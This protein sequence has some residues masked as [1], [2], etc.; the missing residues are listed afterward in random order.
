MKYLT[1]PKKEARDSSRERILTRRAIFL[2]L[3]LG[4]FAPALAASA[5]EHPVNQ[6]I[7]Q[8]PCEGA[9]SPRL[10]YEGSGSYDPGNQKWIHHGGHDSHPQG[11]H[12][13]TFDLK[14]GV[15]EKK[16]PNTS[17]EGV[18]CVNGAYIFDTVNQRFVRFPG[19][20]LGHGYQWSRGVMLKK[21]PVWLY[22]LAANRWT[23]MRPF[24]YTPSIGLGSLNA[25]AAYD[26]NRALTI[27]FGGQGGGNNLFVYD[28]YSNHL[29]RMKAENPPSPRDG[30]GLCYDSKNDV[31]VMFGS[32][33]DD[34][35][36]TWLYRYSTGKWESHDLTP[37]PVGRKVDEYSTTPT[38]AF[39]SANGLS[40]CVTWHDGDGG[41][42]ETW[43]FDAAKLQWTKMNP[44]AEPE[45]GFSRARNMS[46]IAEENLFI[47]ESIAATAPWPQSPQIWTYRIKNAPAGNLPKTPTDLVVTTENGKAALTWQAIDQSGKFHVLRGE[48][49]DVWNVKYAKVATVNVPRFEDTG[50]TSGKTYFYQVKAVAADGTVSPPSLQTRTQPRVLIKP[51][52]SVPAADKV[53]VTWAAHPAADVKGYNVYRGLVNVRAIQKGAANTSDNDPAY[54]QPVVVEV[55]DITDIRKLNDQLLTSAQWTDHVDLKKAEPAEGE[56]RFHVYAYIIKAV[57]K[58]GTESG[59]SPYGLTIP[60]EPENL[61]CREVAGGTAELKWDANPEK[62]ITGYRVYKLRETSEILMVTADPIQATTFSD[63]NEQGTPSEDNRSRYWVVAV[64]AIGQE[65]QPSS[66]AWYNH[67]DFWPDSE[68]RRSPSGSLY[69]GF[70]QGDWHQ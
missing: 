54:A 35:E 21:S 44:L 7:L 55:R 62:G 3:L 46:Y 45:P 11:F 13:F 60:S 4:S 12:T 65:G 14:T 70:F 40:L 26:S 37:R 49:D 23:N 68:G 2:L 59:P 50:L 52:V 42:H 29:V 6:W 48:G 30:A 34:D 58:L 32:Q 66:P 17:P 56:Y 41:R 39:D 36:R 5:A 15:W 47:L 53:E 51:V 67:F 22:D 28:A 9:P 64:D 63:K 31:L 27:S 18:C 33:Y 24:P 38:M 25:S 61:L 16:F 20:S 10:G 1:S 8:S 57:N 43:T 69:K 19:A